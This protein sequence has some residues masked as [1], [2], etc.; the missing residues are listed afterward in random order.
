MKHATRLM[1]MNR[2]T[3][4]KPHEFESTDWRMPTGKVINTKVEEIDGL[5]MVGQ[6][7]CRSQSDCGR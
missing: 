5:K 3:L 7:V 1:A 4:N 6:A 2:T